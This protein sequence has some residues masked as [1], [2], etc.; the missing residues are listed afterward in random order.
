VLA[1]G[2]Q[3][4]TI[5]REMV[6]LMRRIAGRGP[7]KARTTIGRDHVLVMFRETLTQGERN[8]VDCGYHET[9]QR[10]RSAYQDVLKEDATALIER[11]LN[12]RVIGFMSNNH[13]DPDVAVEVF[14]LDP[15]E[16][17]DDEGPQEGEHSD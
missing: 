7:T 9:V 12:R 10:V 17:A 13:F 15:V 11:V 6:Q 1:T 16:S 8:L 4:A 3:A 2:E 5:S 14:I